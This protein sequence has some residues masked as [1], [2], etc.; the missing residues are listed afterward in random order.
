MRNPPIPGERRI[1][2]ISAGVQSPRTDRNGRAARGPIMKEIRF[3]KIILRR[4]GN[5]QKSIV[6][7]NTD[8]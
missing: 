6:R 3:N 1:D 2:N 4:K 8:N 7:T 5:L